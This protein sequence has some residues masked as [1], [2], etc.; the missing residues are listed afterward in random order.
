MKDYTFRKGIELLALCEQAKLPIG[1][2]MLLRELDES[3]RSRDEVLGE[4]AKNLETMRASVE[5]GLS[6]G[7]R[8]VSGL[9][10]GDAARLRAHAGAGESL[11]GGRMLEAVAASMAVVEVNASMGRIVAAPTAG[12]SGILPG[13]L[14]A[15]AKRRGWSDE[16]LLL[17][18]FNAGA[19][20]LVIA[21]NASISGAEGGCQ[22]ETGAAAA[23]AAS[24]LT[25]LSGGTPAQCL[26]AAAMALK[27]VMGLVCD[28]VAGL[29]ECPCI[30]R[31]A[32]GAANA[33][34][35]ADMALAGIE[36]LIPFDEVVLAMKSV[37]RLMS[38]DLRETAR[39]G[40]A[41]TPT[42]RAIA[43]R[44]EE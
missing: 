16:A 10:G 9:T 24:A 39:G 21:K 4:M 32:I 14:L 2:I 35:C 15:C 20:G 38:P 18:L 19:V 34:L 1:E 29:V 7:L 33:L 40:V 8:S 12:A 6:G 17:A 27:N 22:A 26:H 5:E 36:S 41:A 23:M 42:A 43:K 11:S 3:E 25:E 28:P 13:T 31:N 30:K 37:G 44:L